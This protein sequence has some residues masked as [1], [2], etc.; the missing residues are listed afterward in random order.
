MDCALWPQPFISAAPAEVGE[1]YGRNAITVRLIAINVN[2]N[3]V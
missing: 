1:K 2:I 3:L